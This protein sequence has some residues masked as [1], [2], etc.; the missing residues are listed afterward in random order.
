MQSTTV[1]DRLIDK[2]NLMSVYDEELRVD[3]RLLLDKRSSFSVGKKDGLIVVEV[4]DESPQRAADLSNEYVAE[5]RRMTSVLAISEA[6][7]RRVFF[8]NQMKAAREALVRARGLQASGFNVGALRAEPRL[9]QRAMH[10]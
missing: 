5:L 2:F 8:E 6:Q 1:A 3:A 7:Q 9:Q 4:E 10:A